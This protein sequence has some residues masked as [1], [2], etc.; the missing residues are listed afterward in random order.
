MRKGEGF[1]TSSLL[2]EPLIAIRCLRFVY[3]F[4]FTYFFFVFTFYSH[5]LIH[6]I[7]SIALVF[8]SRL[9]AALKDPGKSFELLG[10]QSMHMQF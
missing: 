6:L 7:Y 1:V 2:L 4:L 9:M 10:S 8:Y 5:A 3:T